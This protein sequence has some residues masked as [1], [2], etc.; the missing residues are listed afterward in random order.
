[1]LMLPRRYVLI[2]AEKPKAA[3]KIA[4][5]LSRTKPV[6]YKM[7]GVPYWIVYHNGVPYVIA[8]A[9]GHLF[10]L[11]TSEHGFPVFKYYWVPAWAVDREA[12][13]T[14]PYYLVLKNLCKY[15][16]AFVN[17]CD[18][19]IEGSVIGYLIIKEFGDLGRAYRAKFSTLTS[20]DLRQAFKNLS[21]GLD[22][23]MVE[24][25]LCRH[26]LDWIWGINV[27]RA[28]MY[29]V[30]LATGKRVILSAGRV[31]SPTLVE[32][33][34][35]EKQR[36]LFIPTP[37]F[38]ISVSVAIGGKTY[39]LE[40]LGESFTRKIDAENAL[41]EVKKEKWA[42][43]E[44]VKYE[45]EK[46]KPPPPFNL[47]D[48]QAEAS[49]I[50]GFSPLKT[51]ELAEQLYLDALI[52]YPRTNSQ[53]LPPTINYESIMSKLKEISEYSNLVRDL[54][55][56]TKGI[57]KPHEGVKIDPAHPAIYPTG[58]KP[59][60]LSV[61][62]Q[63]IYDLI[64]KRFL[65]TFSTDT[66]LYSITVYLR[67]ARFKF[68]LKLRRLHLKGWLKYYPFLNI[69]YVEDL[70]LI[71]RG[72]K[73]PIVKARIATTYSRYG[74]FYDKSS[75][76]KWM[77][78][79][80]IGTESTRARIIENLF[81]RGYLKT[82]KGKIEATPLGYAVS[83]ILEK[84]FKDLTSV[85]LTRKFEK[86]LND[87]REG[88]VKRENVVLESKNILSKILLEF[89]N[90]AAEKAGIELGK[91]LKY[92]PVE[93]EC[94]ICGSEA[95]DMK[96]CRNHLRALENILEKYKVWVQAYGSLSWREY[97]KK[98]SSLNVSGKWVRE[99]A[100]GILEGI[101]KVN[102]Q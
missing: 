16:I 74:K 1:M 81:S 33:V 93:S 18:Y 15:A 26:E 14:R 5:A 3:S 54:L 76:L 64:V 42:I 11:T 83:E 52:S 10:A 44:K 94:I 60:K 29:A 73:L 48:L 78:S 39:A 47:G 13:Y 9:A 7:Y 69:D 38:N 32:V 65:A 36:N 43:V 70:P 101:V 55:R 40:Y 19:D 46:I 87:I 89:K 21:K 66:I 49:K 8:S 77:E 102:L 85:E 23:P 50:Y 31:Q 53:K 67:I 86:M 6:K 30:K 28:L 61:D 57:L 99:V 35:T 88:R 91:S 34:N 25:G 24:A 79:V 82:V 98:I 4:Q 59:R 58:L 45:V 68:R 100:K 27:S 2:I 37:M 72:Q 62:Q 84:Y 75:L 22:M 63:K 96:L 80:N 12:R 51:Q 92:I 71:G 97:L 20:Q 90:G 56:E 17:A 95:I 41:K